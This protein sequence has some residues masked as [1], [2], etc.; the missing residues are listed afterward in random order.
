[1]TL[2]I[3]IVA[4]GSGTRLGAD[5]PKAFVP[6]C[7]SSLLARSVRT[8]LAVPDVAQ[9]VVVAPATH[10]EQA[11]AEL[12]DEPRVGVVPGGAERTDSVAA[13]L[14]ALDETVDVVLV[15]DCA[16][17]L[18]PV[19]LFS[20]VAQ[21]VSAGAPA[22]VPGLAVVDTIKAV[23]GD[24]VVVS[25]PDRATLR[26]VQTP[27]GFRREVLARAHASGLA[28]TDDAA[29]VEALGLPV[30]VVEGDPVAFKVTTQEDLARARRVVA[31]LEP[32]ESR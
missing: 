14:A 21:A 10:Q 4:A 13:G 6:V 23:D 20:A 22:V 12:P 28:A 26:A 17:A 29:L 25:T 31:S 19:S 32:E 1:M 15:H 9:V 11:R 18:A 27:Q 3:V 16:R 30:L 5:L 2:A 24:G 8:A 7:G